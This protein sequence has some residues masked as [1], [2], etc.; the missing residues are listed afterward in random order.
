LHIVIGIKDD[1]HI[2][3]EILLDG[4]RERCHKDLTS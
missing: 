2:Q 3:E 4:W 1:M